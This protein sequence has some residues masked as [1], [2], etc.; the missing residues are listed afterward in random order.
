MDVPADK[1][2]PVFIRRDDSMSR[3]CQRTLNVLRG[4]SKCNSMDAAPEFL[5][6]LS[7]AIMHDSAYT[8]FDTCKHIT[9]VEAA[10]I[11]RAATLESIFSAMCKWIAEDAPITINI[12]PN[13][14]SK[15]VTGD[16]IKSAFEVGNRPVDYMTRRREGEEKCFLGL[17]DRNTTDTDRPKYGALN[18][19]N[20]PEG[21][22]SAS[23][24]GQWRLVLK[25][26]VR[27]RCTLAD[28]DTLA[29]PAMGV[30]DFSAHIMLK[31]TD[32]EILQCALIAMGAIPFATG[33]QGPYREVQIHGSLLCSRDVEELHVGGYNTAIAEEFSRT[34]GVK[35]VSTDIHRI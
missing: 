10:K 33:Y 11:L 15:L 2:K 9:R 7:K 18:F 30:L 16:A 12:S 27:Q 4:Q 6:R 21:I 13:T 25:K 5:L 23:V 20:S 19:L 8:I 34:F 1:F 3:E 31:F 17:Y 22:P 29:S 26:S 14:I 28:Q 35:L 24:Y 32:S